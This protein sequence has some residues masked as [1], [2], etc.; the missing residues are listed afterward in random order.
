MSETYV[1][2]TGKTHE[3][4]D[5][6]S[7]LFKIL[8][9]ILGVFLMAEL[10]FYVVVVP[11]T[12][13]IKLTIQGAPAMGYDELCSLAG[14]TGNEKW[15]RFDTA[16]TASIL[17]SNPLFES[18]SVEK[19]FPDRVTISLVER[20]PV[21][22]AL[23]TIN[24]R[25]VP[26]EIDKAGVVFRIGGLANGSSLPLVT[27]LTFDNPVAGMRLNVRL[28]PLLQDLADLEAK[29]PALLSSVSEIKIN[30]K[31]Y[32]GYDLVVYPVH[33]QIRVLTDKALNEDTLQYMMLVLDVVKDMSLAI[34]EIDIRAGTVSYR[35]K[36]EQ[37]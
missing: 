6:K 24:G 23:G 12:S 8:I 9:V 31:T 18:V 16:A 10:A 2:E 28:K 25:T 13:T 32:G 34:D 20:I 15:I 1:V 14:L 33:T 17:A 35:L 27:G 22:V 11:A 37:L 21:A 7:I 36:G 30:E 29:N 5:W 3:A 26:V 19:K 4:E